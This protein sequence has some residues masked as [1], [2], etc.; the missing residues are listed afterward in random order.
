VATYLTLVAA[1]GA[2]RCFGGEG[3]FVS[4]VDGKKVEYTIKYERIMSSPM[5]GADDPT[6]PLN[7]RDAIT[8]AAKSIP[9]VHAA[10]GARRWSNAV[11]LLEHA[12]LVPMG[13]ELVDAQEWRPVQWFWLMT[14]RKNRTD[15]GM[16]TGIPSFTEVVVLMDG[17]VVLPKKYERK[18]VSSDPEDE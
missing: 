3:S 16:G 15:V 17:S 2:D 11:P 13:Y 1:L 8:I 4:E 10:I 7:A 18:A 6:P 9:E 12:K 5:W 14:F